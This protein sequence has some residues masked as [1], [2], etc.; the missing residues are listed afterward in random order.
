[1][2]HHQKSTKRRA[3]ITLSGPGKTRKTHSTESPGQ[4]YEITSEW[5]AASSLKNYMIKD[6]LL[7]WLSYHSASFLR[8]HPDYADVVARSH[9]PGVPPSG[10]GS[11]PA[12]SFLLNQGLEFERNV[13]SYL[14]EQFGSSNVIHLGGDNS[15]AYSKEKYLQSLQAMRDGVPFICSPVLH[16]PETKTF[17]VPDLLV[18]SDWIR[19]FLTLCPLT[20]EEET[21][22]ALSLNGSYHY[23]VIDYKFMTLPF[24]VDGIHLLNEGLIPAYKA[25]L[26]IYNQLLAKAQGY[27][28]GVAYLLGRRWKYK[29][30]TGKYD[31]D[32]CFERLGTVDF[33]GGDQH[34][35]E[36]TFRA[37]DWIRRMRA[38]GSTWDPFDRQHPELYPNMC[39]SHDYPWHE[40]KE[41]LAKDLNEITL[42][43]M[44][45]PKNREIAHSHQIYEWTDER[46]NVDTLG[47]SSR[48]YRKILTQMLK[49]NR[50]NV[51]HQPSHRNPVLPLRIRNNR[52]SWQQKKKL[53][54]FVD[55]ETFNEAVAPPTVPDQTG[56]NLI[57]L[58]GVGYIS[59]STRQWVYRDFLIKFLSSDE[60]YR[61]CSEFVNFLRETSQRYSCPDFPLFHWSSYEKRVWEQAKKRHQSRDVSSWDFLETHWFDFLEVFRKEPIVIQGCFSFKLKDVAKA[62][63]NH[64]LI[65]TTWD[66][67]CLDGYGAMIRAFE[68]LRSSNETV[69]RDIL[70]YN[71]VDCK[72]LEEIVTYLRRN[73]RRYKRRRVSRST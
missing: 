36:E 54:F 68:A 6:P 13:N 52:R 58:I 70:R 66:S 62:L 63:Y 61:I 37:L 5:V 47:I 2:S 64:G 49:V 55:F 28:P 46:C 72:V 23:R 9:T 10:S 25:Q 17:G 51:N 38:E 39:N 69:I 32:S 48:Q 40:V 34:I 53:E 21:V 11:L 57:F 65:S 67:S 14:L 42:L 15:N 24:S 41:R 20:P 3:S 30:Q 1:M 22:P 16:D 60:E 31:G 44:C 26:Y 7:D 73:H 71:E 19:K 56:I 45:G 18:R 29:T 8:K 33:R 12:T 59:P 4:A 35:V 43:W 50:L 27:D